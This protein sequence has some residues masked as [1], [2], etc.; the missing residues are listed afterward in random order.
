MIVAYLFLAI[1]SFGF[2]LSEPLNQKDTAVNTQI[3]SRNFNQSVYV[4][5]PAYFPQGLDADT[6]Q[7]KNSTASSP[8]NSVP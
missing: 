3:F 5:T 2:A 6:L 7:L 8:T 1:L 4:I